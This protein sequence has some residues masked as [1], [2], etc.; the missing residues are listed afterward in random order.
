MVR[1]IVVALMDLGWLLIRADVVFPY[2]GW[3]SLLPIPSLCGRYLWVPFEDEFCPEDVLTMTMTHSCEVSNVNQEPGTR[4]MCDGV[5]IP[6][7]K[8]LIGLYALL[9]N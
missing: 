9:K 6:H 8:N 2:C 1:E 4:D 7:K 3:S 5:M